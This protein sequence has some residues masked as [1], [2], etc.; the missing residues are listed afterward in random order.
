MSFDVRDLRNECWH[1]KKY[2]LVL[3]II[4]QTGYQKF[5]HLLAR[6]IRAIYVPSRKISVMMRVKNEVE[7]L[8]ASVLSIIE[9]VDEIILIDNQSTDGSTV[10]IQ[11]LARRFPAKLRVYSYPLEVARTGY[12]NLEGYLQNPL[13]PHLLANY[14]NWCLSKCTHPFVMKWDGDMIATDAFYSALAAFKNSRYWG[15]RFGG[16]NISPDFRNLILPDMT[17]ELRIFT[18]L[19][20]THATAPTCEILLTPLFHPQQSMTEYGYIHL[21]YC[22]KVPFST[23]SPAMSDEAG[24]SYAGLAV[25]GSPEQRY[26]ETLKHWDIRPTDRSASSALKIK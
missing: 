6:L 8:A 19:F 20:A 7:F 1:R 12:E 21:K 11:E 23:R 14:Y 13:S 25:G 15:L 24:E 4:L 18:K 5:L 3:L 9:Y 16:C 26:I 2:H 10:L 22:K 17:N